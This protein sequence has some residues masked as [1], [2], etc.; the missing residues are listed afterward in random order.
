[1]AS[2]VAIVF[3][4]YDL[5]DWKTAFD[6]VAFAVLMARRVPKSERPGVAR[7]YLRAVGLE[8]HGEKYPQQLSGGQQQRVAI[9]RTL[10]A[11]RPSS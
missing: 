11:I 6:N 5:F 2:E 9:A 4:G 3:Q 1:M 8:D 7:R 10:A